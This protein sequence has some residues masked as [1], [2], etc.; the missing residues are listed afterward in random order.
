MNIDEYLAGAATTSR[1]GTDIFAVDTYNGPDR[2][3]T[4][5]YALSEGISF[6]KDIVS[7]YSYLLN[8][9]SIFTKIG[10]KN[11]NSS[12]CYM[13]MSDINLFIRPITSSFIHDS[14]VSL[15]RIEEFYQ[16]TIPIASCNYSPVF[17]YDENVNTPNLNTST[18]V[19][20]INE[21]DLPP[22][23][24]SFKSHTLESLNDL[25]ER[26]N[27]L[28]NDEYIPIDEDDVSVLRTILKDI[29][30]T[31]EL[32]VNTFQ[33]IF[34]SLSFFDI[35]ISAIGLNL[36][37]P[38]DLVD[39]CN[40]SGN[41][42]TNNDEVSLDTSAD[43]IPSTSARA[44]VRGSKNRK[45]KNS[46]SNT[47]PTAIED[48]SSNN[49]KASSTRGPKAKKKE[50]QTLLMTGSLLNEKFKSFIPEIY[51]YFKLL[52]T[53]ALMRNHTVAVL[54]YAKQNTS[55]PSKVLI[56][57]FLHII[58]GEWLDPKTTDFHNS[59][60]KNFKVL[61][62]LYKCS[63]DFVENMLLY[64][65]SGCEIFYAAWH[66]GLDVTPTDIYRKI[67]N[68]AK[69]YKLSF[70]NI[71]YMTYLV[72][73]IFN[74]AKIGDKFI[75]FNG[76]CR[77]IVDQ[78]EADNMLSCFTKLSAFVLPVAE[79]S[80]V[81]CFSYYSSIGVVHPT[82]YL[83]ENPGPFLTV[84]LYRD[85]EN[86][87]GDDTKFIYPVQKTYCFIRDIFFK[88]RHF[89]KH[90]RSNCLGVILLGPVINVSIPP[91]SYHFQSTFK[92]VISDVNVI[93]TD[94]TVAYNM[95]WP[96]EMLDEFK[97]MATDYSYFGI[98]W[99]N[100]LSLML[101]L[102]KTN[103][104]RKDPMNF[105]VSMFGNKEHQYQGQRQITY[106][107]GNKIQFKKSQTN[108][109]NSDESD[110]ATSNI[111]ATNDMFTLNEDGQGEPI[112]FQRMQQ[113]LSDLRL[114]WSNVQFP[115]IENISSTGN[116]DLEYNF[117]AEVHK[118]KLNQSVFA[119]YIKFAKFNFEEPSKICFD[120]MPP[121]FLKLCIT[122]FSWF[123]R[124][125]DTHRYQ[126][127][128]FMKYI[129]KNRME[130][131]HDFNDI[132]LKY[133]NI[134]Y[135]NIKPEHHVKIFQEYCESVTLDYANIQ[136]KDNNEVP[137]LTKLPNNDQS[138]Q[139]N[140]NF[141]EMEL[142]SIY[143]AF[144]YLI[145]FSNYDI[146][147]FVELCKIMASLEYCGNYLKKMYMFYGKSMGGKNVFVD[148]MRK[149]YNCSKKIKLVNKFYINSSQDFNPNC[150]TIGTSMLVNLDEPPE[151]LKTS[152]LKLDVNIDTISSRSLFARDLE[153]YRVMAKMF[154]TSNE[155]VGPAAPDD[156]WFKRLALFQVSHTFC[157][158]KNAVHRTS[159]QSGGQLFNE[160]VKY[161]IFQ[162]LMGCYPENGNAP[163]LT[164]GLTIIS[165]VLFRRMFFFKDTIPTS[166]SMTDKCKRLLYTYMMTFSPFFEFLN[167]TVIVPSNDPITSKEITEF[168]RNWCSIHKKSEEPML[169][170]VRENLQCFMQG[171]SLY[172]VRIDDRNT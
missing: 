133:F 59:L 115:A 36:V 72:R 162:I 104:I 35:I 79:T 144:S 5:Y 37:I 148:N 131:Y 13:G 117:T 10:F 63:D 32:M 31:T 103:T 113:L 87:L 50:T 40:N 146:D 122:I 78:A 44:V 42:E 62:G 82:V 166:Y 136:I 110:M 105:I 68:Q 168:V 85:F 140:P 145:T 158:L 137:P 128:S 4:F 39:L 83:N 38:S 120:N 60:R 171:T 16:Q 112:F 93:I 18:T 34:E 76:K 132:V 2:D 124:I 81:G 92:P 43:D 28:A 161:L 142:N 21:N 118:K 3:N 164:S 139:I 98:A 70:N 96:P 1:K 155:W 71:T 114:E 56:K 91:S 121:E 12:Y 49:N 30:I 17:K 160:S 129:A 152:E 101:T 159:S 11:S 46:L 141:S 73:Q 167:T 14:I 107:E 55:L 24:I 127:S 80:T 163:N 75:L 157:E 33:K 41:P 143:T 64:S 102:N 89:I 138:F 165:F 22:S 99:N 86:Y 67:S 170:A 172:Y 66:F 9:T 109:T 153:E 88:A 58:W 135:I 169:N 151:R 134:G 150:Y 26:S 74:C 52:V 6:S 125:G 130:I 54:S 48:D 8:S 19:A 57:L 126:D 77:P 69:R 108:P 25:V 84:R 100:F 90:M 111:T 65:Y 154:V 106:L 23:R 27:M 149:V 95:N 15:S 45:R 47:V 147:T 123:I 29:T 97:K 20:N 53:N 94:L 51:N 61:I 156:G 116:I 7:T 119:E